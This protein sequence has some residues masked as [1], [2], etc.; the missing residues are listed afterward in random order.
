MSSIFTCIF[1]AGDDAPAAE[2]DSGPKQ[3][4]LEADLDRKAE[5]AEI[6]GVYGESGGY[7]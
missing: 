3:P 2:E 6:D 1:C 7:A 5:E 4:R